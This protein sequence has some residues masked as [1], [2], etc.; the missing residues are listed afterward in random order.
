MRGQMRPLNPAP[1]A[2]LTHGLSRTDW[3]LLHRWAREDNTGE[4]GPQI[5]EKPSE[6]PCERPCDRPCEMPYERLCV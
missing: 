3:P 6:R 5:Q 2:S 4:R 1:T